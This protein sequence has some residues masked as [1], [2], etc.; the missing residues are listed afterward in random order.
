MMQKDKSFSRRHGFP[1][2]ESEISVRNDAPVAVRHAIL[3]IAEGEMEVS[4][5]VLRDVLCTILRKMPDPGNWSQYPNI[6]G[7]CQELIGEAAW[8]R[9]YDFVEALYQ[10]LE[11][12]QELEDAEEWAERINEYFLE[13]GVGWR[14]VT[15]TLESR[16]AEGFE[17]SVA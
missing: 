17:E 5:G 8:Y 1:S 11:V 15:G 14:I 2:E 13:A 6:W 9:V 3:K 16:G 10:E 12:L 7:E 4:P